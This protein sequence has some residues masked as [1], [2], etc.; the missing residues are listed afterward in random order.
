M[1]TFNQ[2]KISFFGF[3][4]PKSGPC[5]SKRLDAAQYEFRSRP[6]ADVL[7]M[8]QMRRNVCSVLFSL[9]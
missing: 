9:L 6:K 1:P 3:A 8:L 2:P 5:I 7:E 4:S